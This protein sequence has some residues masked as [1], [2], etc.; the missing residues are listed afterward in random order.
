MIHIVF[1]TSDVH[2]I[3]DAIKLDASLEGDVIEIRD[4]F[5]VGPIANIYETE[6]YEARRD[7]RQVL[8]FS[9]Y[10]GEHDIINDKLTVHHLIKKLDEDASLQAWIWMG[11]NAH[12]V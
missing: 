5:A 4:E 7:W 2:A 12:D 8:E 1:Q 11:Q 9:S 3:K 10:A 6:G